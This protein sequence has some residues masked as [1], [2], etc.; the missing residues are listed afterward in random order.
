ML[1]LVVLPL[2]ISWA[3]GVGHCPNDGDHGV[4]ASG[5]A[6]RGHVHDTDDG[7]GEPAAGAGIDCSAFHLVA[8]E[9]PAVS[10]QPLSC[11]GETAPDV[12]YSG[13]KSHI[14]SGLDRPKWRFAA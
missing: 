12:A 11:A 2:Q 6:S 1:L 8:L 9:P 3:A 4:H 14:P 5:D 13:Y 10:T 7:D